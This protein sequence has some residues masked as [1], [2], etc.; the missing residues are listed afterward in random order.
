VRLATVIII[1]AAMAVAQVH[2]RRCEMIARHQTEQLLL[3]RRQI[4][5][6]LW[7]QQIALSRLTNPQ[8]VCR[9]GEEMSLG[10]VERNRS[11]LSVHRSITERTATP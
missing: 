3:E 9:R 6:T 8:E 1:L 4:R 11:A 5:R 2:M 10:L 7:D